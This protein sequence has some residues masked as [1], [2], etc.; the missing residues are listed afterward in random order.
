MPQYRVLIHGENF[1]LLHG[2]KGDD[3]HPI[4]MG[5]FTNRFL[6]SATDYP[7]PMSIS[8]S[9]T[10]IRELLTPV[11][12]EEDPPML[13]IQ[14]IWPVDVPLC[15]EDQQYVQGLFLYPEDKDAHHRW[16]MA[17][18]KA[19]SRPHQGKR[20]RRIESILQQDAA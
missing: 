9:L 17:N 4:K 20:Y 12:D 16:V 6:E 1:L 5:F 2:V 11:N 13:M 14:E 3:A 7:S 8:K 19:A 10:E 15:V 18:F